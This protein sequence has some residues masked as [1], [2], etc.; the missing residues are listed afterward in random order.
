MLLVL[1]AGGD[2]LGYAICRVAS[3][4]GPDGRWHGVG[5]IHWLGLCLFFLGCALAIIIVCLGYTTSFSDVWLTPF[6]SWIPFCLPIL[7]YY[8]H[9]WAIDRHAAVA[10]DLRIDERIIIVFFSIHG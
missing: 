5:L 3:L 6:G 2:V 1:F 10:T 7:S 8:G 9:G 4:A